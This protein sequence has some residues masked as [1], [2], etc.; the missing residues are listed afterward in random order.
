M[1]SRTRRVQEPA[2]EHLI[3]PGTLRLFCLSLGV[4]LVLLFP[5]HRLL[6]LDKADPLPSQVAIF[7]SQA[8]LQANPGND[9]LRVAL[10]RR[11]MQVG[12]LQTA[13]E[14]LAPLEKR[15]ETEIQ[16]LLLSIDW[17]R[18]IALEET[19]AQRLDLRST[20]VT[21][22]EYVR[23]LPLATDRLAQIAD[24]WLALAAPGRA[25][26]IYEKLAQQDPGERYRWLS[27][28]GYWW[29][30]AGEPDRSAAAWHKAYQAAGEAQPAQAR[31]EARASPGW[32]AWL[33]PAVHAQE[34]AS[35]ESPQRAAAREALLAAEQ[36]QSDTGV[37]YAREYL[38]HFPHDRELLNIGIRLALAHDQPE[39]AFAWSQR[40]LK[41][42]EDISSLE[43]HASIALGLNR[44]DA[45]LDALKRLYALEPGRHQHLERLAQAQ[46]WADRPQEALRS[47]E[48]LARLSGESRHERWLISLALSLR[49][50]SI[51]VAALNRL[52][53]QGEVTLDERRLLVD[54]LEELGD[55]EGAIRRIQA[56]NA[57]G[58]HDHELQARLATWLEQTGRLEEAEAGWAELVHRHG[59]SPDVTQTRSRLLA[60]QWRLEEAHALLAETQPSSFDQQ[61]WQQRAQLAWNLG[62]PMASRKAY[63]ALFEREALDANDASRLLYSIGA[64][65]DLDLA[66]RVTRHRWEHERDAEAVMQMFYLAQRERDLE[67][68]Q[69]VLEM[70]IEDPL[71]FEDSAEYWAAQA[72]QYLARREAQA[73]VDAYR[74]ALALAGADTSLRT[75][76]LYALAAAGELEELRERLEEWQEQAGQDS[77]MMNAMA[78][79]HRQLGDLHQAMM[80]HARA[81]RTPQDAWQ[82]LDHADTLDLAGHSAQAFKLR[83]AALQELMPELAEMLGSGM[84]ASQ[85]QHNEHVR[86]MGVQSLLAGP[87]SV[88]G[89]YRSLVL[90]D[91][92]AV[93]E[94]A[95]WL[96]EAHI[97]MQQQAH[98]R[99]LLLRARELGHASPTW[100]VLAVALEQNDKHTLRRLRDEKGHELSAADHLAIQRQLDR[101]RPALAQAIALTNQGH[102]HR[103]EA[104]ELAREMPHRLTMHNVYEE[105]GDLSLNTHGVGYE[106]SGERLYARLDARHRRLW[107]SELDID[108]QGLDEE[109]DV[110]LRLG[111][112][113]PRLGTELLLGVVDTPD[114]TQL[115]AGL[116]QR[117]HMTPR[118]EGTLYGEVGRLSEA[119]ERLRLLGQEDRFGAR[120]D[121]QFTA[122]NRISLDGSHVIYRDRDDRARLGDGYRV[123]TE[124]S[125]ALIQ[126]ATRH[127]ELRL[128][129]SHEDYSPHMPLPSGLQNRLNSTVLPEEL[130]PDHSS[131]LGI[132]IGIG[133]GEP[134]SAYPQAASPRLSLDLDAG[135]RLP[136]S[137]FASSLGL[138]VGSRVL[139]NDELSLRLNLDQGTGPED[140]LR[141]G[142]TLTYQ[143]FLGR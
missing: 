97:A 142:I 114:T 33:I 121:W 36:S 136:D 62:D 108:L 138:A 21:R 31:Q 27:L 82:H 29:L 41:V 111:W 139:G 70:A 123:E 50:R 92:P 77:D 131:F 13:R 103:Q 34:A 125:H 45:A 101:R 124:L 54:L 32:M 115:Q 20:L 8:L 96:I 4:T 74:R 48:E 25:A 51:A 129:A 110:A 116:T 134:G 106:V 109:Q 16:W 55:P 5:A 61:Y 38:G 10:A 17:Q 112:N 91:R 19:E 90:A 14:T 46:Q 6:S 84:A 118:L 35:E 102:D 44:L 69:K 24:Y 141:L 78:A 37:E 59:S 22:L 94:D 95:D 67:L 9:E 68:A 57:A 132:G 128:L 3:R 73:A 26:A 60:Q 140:D 52:E 30:K 63:Q 15:D 88:R 11:L 56:W 93:L 53:N 104:V 85:V 76:M 120:L 42:H 58:H 87:G 65:A 86:A 127:M 47:V 143:Y 40:Y 72:T 105:L 137:T 43:R 89:W 100:Q 81:A 49:E 107:G 119:N 122:R 2:A 71:L 117:W 1:T 80:W 7:Y 135:M 130:I 133:R 66:I 99:Y 64:D 75:G 39:Q 98:A 79:G 12:E 18:Y 113:G 126:G 28:A 83:R 23:T